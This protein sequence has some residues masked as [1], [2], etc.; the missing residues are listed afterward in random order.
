MKKRIGTLDQF[1]NEKKLK[2]LTKKKW[3][4]MKPEERVDYTGQAVDDFDDAEKFATYDW[5]KLPDWVTS[6]MYESK[7]SNINEAK[8]KLYPEDCEPNKLYKVGYGRHQWES[9]FVEWRL[10][11][12]SYTKHAIPC[13]IWKEQEGVKALEWEAYMFEGKMCVGSSSDTLIVY[14]ELKK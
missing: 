12:S 9:E 6:S 13:M 5:D 14:G 8:S 4:K 7:D 3:D 1:V 10:D 2:L 11:K